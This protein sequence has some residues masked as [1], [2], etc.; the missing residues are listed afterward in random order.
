MTPEDRYHELTA[1][2]LNADED[3][4]WEEQFDILASAGKTPEQ[5]AEDVESLRWLR[6]C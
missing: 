1:K 6:L 2:L 4:T 3:V 5:L